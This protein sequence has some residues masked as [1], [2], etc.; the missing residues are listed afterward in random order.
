MYGSNYRMFRCIECG[1]QYSAARYS[2]DCET[3]GSGS[4]IDPVIEV[5][6]DEY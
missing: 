5:I 4:W 2:P 1:H 6:Q 3:C